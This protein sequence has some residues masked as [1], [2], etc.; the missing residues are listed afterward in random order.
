MTVEE[1]PRR[2]FITPPSL[3]SL[4]ALNAILLYSALHD[5]ISQT[6]VLYKKAGRYSVPG[7]RQIIVIRC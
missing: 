5:R 2:V 3:R 4:P 7:S 1:D 6:I